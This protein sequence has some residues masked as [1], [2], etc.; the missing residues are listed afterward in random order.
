MR[1]PSSAI[2]RRALVAG[3]G[4]LAA[5]GA[6][7]WRSPRAQSESQHQLLYDRFLKRIS[8]TE[9]QEAQLGNELEKSMIRASGGP[10]L[11]RSIQVAI[12]SFALPLFEASSK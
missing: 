4:G 7:G 2:S 3:A 12:E 8:L 10:Y 11:N 9:P 6:L 1:N 5:L